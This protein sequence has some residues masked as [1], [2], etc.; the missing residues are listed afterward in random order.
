MHVQAYPL[1]ATTIFASAFLLFAVQPMAGKHLLPFFGGSSSVWATGLLFFTGVLFLG[2][3]Y[4]YFLTRYGVREQAKVHLYVVAASV[5]LVIAWF[6]LWGSLYPSLEWTAGSA[7]SPA[8]LALVA[9]A[10]SVGVPYFLLATTGPLLQYWY[11]IT[12]EKEPYK[13]YAISNAGS[14]LAL[15]SYPFLV[16]PHTRLFEQEIAWAVLFCAY[17]GLALTVAV[18]VRRVRRGWGPVARP[19]ALGAEAGPRASAAAEDAWQE[20]P[21]AAS[22]LATESVALLW[23]EKIPWI[24]YAA[25]PSFVLVAVTTQLTQTI[26]AIPLLWILPLSI[27]LITFI[28]AFAGWRLM[29]GA[30]AAFLMSTL[31]FASAAASWWFIDTAFSNIEWKI[32][33]SLALLFFAGLVCHGELYA[34]RPEKK[35]LPLFY[36]LLSLCGVLGTL[37]ASIFAPIIFNDYWEIPLSIALSG[38]LAAFFTMRGMEGRSRAIAHGLSYALVGLILAVGYT[39]ASRHNDDYRAVERNFYGTTKVEETDTYRSLMHGGTMHGLQYF[40][41]EFKFTPAAYYVEETGLGRAIAYTRRND[42]EKRLSLAVVGLG[43]GMTAAYCREG[44]AL[45]YYEIDR[46][47]LRLAQSEFSYLSR[48][49]QAEVRIGDARVL[50]EKEKREGTTGRYDVIA[51]DAFNDDTIPVH[52]ITREAIDLYRAHLS[53]EDGVIA[54]HISNRY[55]DL[56]PP[57]LAIA[58]ELGLSVIFVE[59]VSES[60]V[61]SGSAWVLLSPST[62]VFNA[63][64]FADAASPIPTNHVRAW[65]DDYSDILSIL[66]L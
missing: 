27:Y 23:R 25:F 8:F 13:L 48:C 45:T 2:Y 64:E 21:P 38:I 44:D 5:A 24:L 62:E 33:A 3:L 9:L 29:Q 18:R 7:L 19:E 6:L 52:L 50:L 14:L 57:L 46:R 47:I 51:I 30:L 35:H 10:I 1:Y 56:R 53:G 54:V 55:L 31:L 42:P 28:V 4:V 34:R 26:A 17:A 60:E 22:S 32:A 66:E 61:A 37:A 58:A 12:A 39:Y 43:A 36:L 65:T 11:G 59:T 20:V 16:E 63:K 49:P 40:A 15:L 41:E